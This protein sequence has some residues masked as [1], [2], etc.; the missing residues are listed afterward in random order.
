M[1]MLIGSAVA[2]VL[3]MLLV[4]VSALSRRREVTTPI[5][6]KTNGEPHSHPQDGDHQ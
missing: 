3:I 4:L 1:P 5:F 6:N 2:I